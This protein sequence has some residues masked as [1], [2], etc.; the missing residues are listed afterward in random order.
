M[1]KLIAR[2]S[3]VYMATNTVTGEKYIGFTSVSLRKRK[4]DHLRKC[5][6]K[7]TKFSD[8][9]TKYG[10]DA[11]EWTVV[12]KFA[13]A[14]EACAEEQ[15]LILALNPEYN[16]TKGGKA[17]VPHVLSDEV[18]A[19]LS[20]HGTKNISKWKR[21][22]HLGPASIAKP[23]I[24]VDDGIIFESASAA[25]R[26]YGLAKSLVIEQCSGNH[27]RRSAGGK[28]FQ[29]CDDHARR[30]IDPQSEHRK[31][32]RGG[33]NPY[34]GV[35]PHISEGKDTGKWRARIGVGGRKNQKKLSLGIFDTP[36][37]ALA[38]VETARVRVLNGERLV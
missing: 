5:R 3:V 36:E 26:S 31:P 9:I 35:H 34:R 4:T 24:C 2:P 25:A 27:R 1:P 18:K 23:V 38:A 30:P 33:K 15:R 11:F 28:I 21:Y 29:Y 20:A 6:T 19:Q 17:Y 22:A 37:A 16:A 8:A 7:T 12:A 32:H 10:R 13:T 14:Q